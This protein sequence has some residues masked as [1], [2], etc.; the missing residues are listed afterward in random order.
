MEEKV[1]WYKL[2]EKIK[3]VDDKVKSLKISNI[4]VGELSFGFLTVTQGTPFEV[5]KK[6]IV[7][8]LRAGDNFSNIGYVSAGVAFVATGT[9]PT[10]WTNNSDILKIVENLVEYYND[11]DP[12]VY[13]EYV[14]GNTRRI[15]ITNGGFT[16]LK[17]FPN[18]VGGSQI[19]VVDTNT[20][21]FNAQNSPK[22]FKI[23]VYK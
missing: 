3:K 20:I 6:Y 4:I 16:A 11:L 19:D 1:S 12:N 10:T 9:T 17:T 15:K 8:N 5:G 18:I 23:E 22:Y 2:P 7:D 13:V 21:T 14:S